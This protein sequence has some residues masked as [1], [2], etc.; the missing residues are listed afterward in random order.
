VDLTVSNPDKVLFP[1]VAP[2]GFPAVAPDGFPAVAPDGD[3]AAPQPAIT[4]L[5]VVQHYAAV[6]PTMLRFC[7]GRPLTLQRFPKGIEAKGFMQKNASDHFPESIERL[8]VPKRGGGETVYPVVTSAADLSWL[9]NQNTVTFHMWTSS[10]RRPGRPDWLILDLD[11]QA[12]DLDGVRSAAFAVKAVL[13]RFGVAS[14]PVATGS[15]GFHLWTPV[16]GLDFAAASLAGRAV[17]GLASAEHPDTLTTEF[18]KKN[19]KGRVFADWLRNAPTATVVVPFSLRPR[20][21]APM[22]APVRW[23][24]LSEAR[25]D[26]HQPLSPAVAIDGPSGMSTAVRDATEAALGLPAQA[27]PVDELVAAARAAGVDLDTP[28]DRF[29]RARS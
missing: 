12:D 8:P 21:G 22:A 16:A 26:Q 7:R 23:D 9:A 10:A 13:D 4:K 11:P 15:K 14:F 18:L 25:P 6:G 1:A 24:D 2:D 3:R 29:G 5:E 17:A 27:V 28:H 20:P 19:R